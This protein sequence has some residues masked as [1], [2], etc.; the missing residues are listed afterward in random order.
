M[1]QRAAKTPKPTQRQRDLRD[2]MLSLSGSLGNP[3]T[4]MRGSRG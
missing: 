1:N 2:Q 3:A 4:W